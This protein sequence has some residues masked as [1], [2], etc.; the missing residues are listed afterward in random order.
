MRA[1]LIL[2]AGTLLGALVLPGAGARVTHLPGTGRS[3]L[4]PSI[5]LLEQTTSGGRIA[6]ARGGDIFLINPDGT[7][8]TQL[9]FSAHGAFYY[10]PALSPDGTRVAFGSVNHHQSRISIIDVDGTGL[11]DLTIN[12]T[13]Y[14]SEPAWSPDGSKIAFVRGYDPTM[15]GIANFTKCG[16]SQIFI[17][18]VDAAANQDINLTP[19]WNGTDPAW[20]PDGERIAFASKLDDNLDICTVAISDG[21]VK[22]LTRTEAQEAE[23]IWSPDGTQIAYARGYMV[24][25]TNCGFEHTGSPDDPPLGGNGPQIY[26]MRADGTD[27]TQLTSMGNNIEPTWSPDG[28]SL[29]FV[30]FRG[31]GAQLYVLDLQQN[32]EFC[33]T[34]D[35]SYKSSPS[36][37]RVD[38]RLPTD[39]K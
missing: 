11:R 4:P 35:S 15:D 8:L 30:G 24:A 13:S 6:F 7:G 38:P 12:D 22:Q 25:L 2:V 29:A 20:S 37:S 19:G 18:N 21:V 36:W 31:A 32:T 1:T 26:V 3:T 28:A 39:V 10:Q 17:V 14:D 23:P 33:I 9:T 5:K 27:Q 16:P 34:S